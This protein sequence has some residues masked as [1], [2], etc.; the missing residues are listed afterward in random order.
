MCCNDIYKTNEV[1]SFFIMK[2]WILLLMHHKNNAVYN[3]W[4][5]NLCETNFLWRPWRAIHPFLRFSSS[6]GN[7]CNNSSVYL[8]ILGSAWKLQS[9]TQL[10]GSMLMFEFSFIK[11]SD[12]TTW[13]SLMPPPDRNG[14]I[15]IFC[16]RTIKQNRKAFLQRLIGNYGLNRHPELHCPG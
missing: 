16:P 7:W 5:L 4:L 15:I 1:K 12:G 6:S 13:L 3:G 9:E 8:I 10:R 14:C 2:L 11:F